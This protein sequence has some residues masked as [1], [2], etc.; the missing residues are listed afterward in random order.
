M[1]FS[2]PEFVFWPFFTVFVILF[3]IRQRQL[4]PFQNGRRKQHRGDIQGAEADYSE[5]LRKEPD[6]WKARYNRALIRFQ[7]GEAEGAFDDVSRVVNLN[8]RLASAFIL[9]AD[10]YAARKQFDLAARDYQQV[11]MLPVKPAQKAY[12]KTRLGTLKIAEYHQIKPSSDPARSVLLEHALADF[13]DALRIDPA[14]AL[15]LD[16]K[17]Q[18]FRL[19]GDLD[20]A[21]ALY[22]QAFSRSP[23]SPVLLTDRATVYIAQGNLDAAIADCDKAIYLSGGKIAIAYNNRGYAHALRGDLELALA[24]CN[25]A[26]EL[27]PR[28]YYAFCSRAYT[29]FLMGDFDAALADFQAALDI[30]SEHN[31][32]LA[33]KAIVL[34]HLDR[35]DEA[36]TTWRALLELDSEYADPAKL[37]RDYSS[38]D[39]FVE[40]AR[41]VA[42]LLE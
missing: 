34:Y 38:P 15:A 3:I 2:R 1:I 10:L 23:Y 30:E 40:D 27:S 24:D 13:D 19:K 9:R 18:V 36:K 4:M 37:K 11:L 41:K 32:A 42:A 28:L 31:Y 5:M 6:F 25:R 35:T 39:S 33:G 20:A 21:L 26:I 12:A 8:P 14:N 16:C 22:T 7:R 17:A 29:Y